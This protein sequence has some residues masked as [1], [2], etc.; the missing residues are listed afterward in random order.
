MTKEREDKRESGKVDEE[1]GKKRSC[2]IMRTLSMIRKWLRNGRG[3][4]K[5]VINR[6]GQRVIPYK[7]EEKK[8][9]VKRRARRL[10]KGYRYYCYYYF[11]QS[12]SSSS[13]SSL[14]SP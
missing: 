12:S 8:E 11:L 13:S 4:A 7:A 3:R 5:R 10:R 2:E 1:A 14:S 9:E 6:S